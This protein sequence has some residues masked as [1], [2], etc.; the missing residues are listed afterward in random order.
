[1]VTIN[2]APK[3]V[4]ISYGIFGGPLHSSEMVA[5]LRAAGYEVTDDLTLADTIIAHS[6]GCWNIPKSASPKLILLIGVALSQT[7]PYKIFF[8]AAGSN[9]GAFIK[10]RHLLHG[11]ALCCKS[12]FYA[13]SQPR[14]NLRIIMRAPNAKLT[15]FSG[16]K[17]VCIANHFDPWPNEAN[18]S[19]FIHDPNKHNWA[20]LS[21]PGSH[22]NIWEDPA[23]YVAIM[24]I[25]ARLLA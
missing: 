21:L 6:A 13:I 10:N 12:L 15:E 14:R 24:D 5:Q 3:R 7:S 11:L 1:M 2:S 8:R 9:A 17:I 16:A 19:E 25:Y 23:I 18:V 20:F 4:A 22:D